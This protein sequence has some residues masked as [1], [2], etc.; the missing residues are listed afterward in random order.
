MLS[1]FLS[2]LAIAAAQEPGF[3]Y[4]AGYGPP[5]GKPLQSVSEA[6]PVPGLGPV[7]QIACGQRF[8]L[9]LKPDGSVMSWGENVFGVLGQGLSQAKL[10]ASATPVPV[11]LP[12]V[13]SVG[14]GAATA[15]AVTTDG[16]LY[17]WGANGS[18]QFTFQTSPKWSS[19]P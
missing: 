4:S 8:T 6:G 2:T 3:V 11:S 7:T 19:T 5:A 15:F 18:K 12:A 14:A 9:A 1:L 16:D 17:A 10:W 13:Q